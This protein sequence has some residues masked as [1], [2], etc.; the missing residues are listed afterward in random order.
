MGRR[1]RGP[2]MPATVSEV[3][4]GQA[5]TVVTVNADIADWAARHGYVVR[6]ANHRG[7]AVY[8]IS[9]GDG[10]LEGPTE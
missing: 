10:G 6:T 5:G 2:G 3:D 7:A 8:E 4:R 1:I 9:P